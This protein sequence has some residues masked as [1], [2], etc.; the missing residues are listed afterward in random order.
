MK[1]LLAVTA[2]AALVQSAAAASCAVATLSKLLLDQYIDQCSDDSGYVF[3][4]GVKP[5]ETEVAG[6]CAS[7]ACHSLL[8][9]VEAMN[10]TECTLPIGDKIY[11]FADLIDYVSEQCEADT[12]APTTGTPEPTTATLTPTTASP[13]PTTAIASCTSAQLR[14]L[15]TSTYEAQC[16]TDTGYSFTSPT[17]PTEA[18][19]AAMCASESCVNLFAYVA[20]MVTTDCRIPVGGKILLLADLVEYVSDQCDAAT[21]APTTGTPTPTTETPTTPSPTTA[22]PVATCKTSVLSSLL[23]DQYIDQCGD[24][25]GYSFTS[26]K[27]PE[28][29]E[30]VGMCASTACANLLADVEALGL[31]ECILPIG[32]KIY[33][34]RDLVNYVSDQCSASTTPSTT[35]PATETPSTPAPSSESP[36]TETPGT[37]TPATTAPSEPSTPATGTDSPVTPTPATETP[38]TESP[39][40][41]NPT[42]NIP[43]TETPEPTSPTHDAC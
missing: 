42:T 28:A 34:F 26:G 18:N 13:A 10:M 43:T 21:P 23:T 30:V 29:E 22:T 2:V 7:D 41:E 8:S 31:S 11:L 1:L 40:T 36:G 9:D 32:D 6:M 16:V 33:L 35:E 24:D 15:L 17:S 37:E 27:Q 19:V 5:T 20:S 3:T 25:S 4:T 14:Y 39:T 12:P 38:G